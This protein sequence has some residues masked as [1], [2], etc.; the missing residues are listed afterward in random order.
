VAILC[1][2]LF[3]AGLVV[4]D[5]INPARVLAFLDVGGAWDPSLALVMGSALVPS[6]LAYLIR[7]RI[8]APVLDVRC[9]IPETRSIDRALV[10]GAILF[11]AGWGQ[12]G[13]CPGPAMAVLATGRWQAFVFV[14]AMLAGMA[15]FRFGFDK[16]ARRGRAPAP[17]P[18]T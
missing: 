13:L 15:L 12:V 16:T 18:Q 6:S 14:A 8:A 9:H 3:G 1:G 11:G 4:S 5:M 10:I 2:A 17:L 7:R